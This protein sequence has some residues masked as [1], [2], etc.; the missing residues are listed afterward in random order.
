MKYTLGDERIL[1]CK[2]CDAETTHRVIVNKNGFD[3]C[4]K[5]Q[6]VH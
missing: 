1:F 2:R 5:C 6:F 4:T 3:I